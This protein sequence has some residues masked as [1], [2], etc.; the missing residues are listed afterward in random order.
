MSGGGRNPNAASSSSTLMLYQ[1]AESWLYRFFST[2]S[3]G[4]T[5]SAGYRKKTMSESM[6]TTFSAVENR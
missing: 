1:K 6:L 5:S 2:P 3:A 4:T